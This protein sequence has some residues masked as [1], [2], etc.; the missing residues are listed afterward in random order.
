MS[1]KLETQ[2]EETKVR[3]DKWRRD[4][5]EAVEEVALL[6]KEVNELKSE[7]ALHS[8]RAK[9]RGD[10][11]E[12]IQVGQREAEKEWNGRLDRLNKINDEQARAFDT[13][14]QQFEKISRFEST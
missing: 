2:L 10:D 3:E 1:A 8:S 11:L 9:S 7:I 6:K 4:K 5:D 13:L 12:A 14:K